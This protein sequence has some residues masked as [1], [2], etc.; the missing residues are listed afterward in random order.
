MDGSRAIRIGKVL[1]QGWNAE[2]PQPPAEIVDLA[3]RV[4]YYFVE[5]GGQ[6]TSTPREIEK[7]IVA[8]ARRSRTKLPSL[9]SKELM[10]SIAGEIDD[11]FAAT[12]RAELGTPVAILLEL[13][14]PSLARLAN[15]PRKTRTPVALILAEEAKNLG[16]LG[17]SIYSHPDPGILRKAMRFEN[18]ESRV[19]IKDAEDCMAELG[20]LTGPVGTARGNETELV[21]AKEVAKALEKILRHLHGETERVFE[22]H[23][24][25]Y[26][27]LT[28][29]EL[30]SS[31]KQVRASLYFRWYNAV[32]ESKERFGT[33]Y[34]FNGPLPKDQTARIVEQDRRAA[35]RAHVKKRAT[36]AIQELVGPIL[37]GAGVI[38]SL[39]VAPR[40]DF[41][42]PAPQPYGVSSRGAELWVADALKWLGARKVTVTQQ[43]GDGGVDVLTS[44][45]AV[46]VK[47]YRG[48][49]PVE[50]VRE[51][52]G[53]S[54]VMNLKPMLWTSGTLT[55]SG[56]AFADLAPVPAFHYNVETAKIKA[57]NS[58][59]Q[60]LL[61]RGL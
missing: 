25:E 40:A 30:K 6:G 20:R 7:V 23:T 57:L 52:F 3:R 43:S 53:V 29:T 44:S 58:G 31:R 18:H 15:T 48:S 9:T 46:S 38:R 55:R 5:N 28:P 50:E 27:N 16:Y 59:A 45:Y 12:L 47:H 56:A 61:D 32:S 8:Q 1:G 14:A 4:S 60:E 39:N 37:N 41:P 36:A 2:Y 34:P 17:A 10:A 42:R 35:D 33:L 11:S 24:G 51:I 49:I 21:G 22:T 54:T 26:R 19:T 13:Q